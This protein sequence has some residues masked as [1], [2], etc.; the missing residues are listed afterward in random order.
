MLHRHQELTSSVR[1]FISFKLQAQH[2]VQSSAAQHRV[3]SGQLGANF[4][5]MRAT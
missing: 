4:A 1:N 2:F 5:C 3:W